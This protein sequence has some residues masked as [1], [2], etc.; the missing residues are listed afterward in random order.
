MPCHKGLLLLLLLGTML[1]ESLAR[2]DSMASPAMLSGCCTLHRTHPVRLVVWTQWKSVSICC[3]LQPYIAAAL[4][5]RTLRFVSNVRKSIAAAG[6]GVLPL[7]L[8]LLLAI[9]AMQVAL[10]GGRGA[11]RMRGLRWSIHCCMCVCV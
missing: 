6:V 10:R 2:H 7:L 9:C 5:L 3:V 11:C 1:K 8:L 4:H